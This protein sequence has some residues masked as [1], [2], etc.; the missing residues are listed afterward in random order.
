MVTRGHG[1]SRGQLR[2]AIDGGNIW[3]VAPSYQVASAIWIDLKRACAGAWVKKSE[4]KFRIELPG[5]G[6]VTVKSADNPESLRGDG[7]DGLVIDEA[8][9]ISKPEVWRQALRP[10]LSDKQGWAV[11]IGSPKGFNWLYDLWVAAEH[12]PGWARWQRPS[13][14]NPLMTASELA[15][16]KREAGSLA[17]AQEYEAQFTA[18]GLG[19]FLREWFMGDGKIVPA[20]PA[21][22]KRAIRYWDKAA[23]EAG[24]DFSAGVLAAEHDGFT[25]IADVVRGQWSA[26]VRNQVIGDT[27]KRDNERFPRMWTWFEQEGG[28][29]GK[30]SAELSREQMRKLGFLANTEKVTD[31]KNVRAMDF[32]AS[33]EAGNVRLIK[34]PW[35]AAFIDE[36]CVFTGSDNGSNDDQVDAASGAHRKLSKPTKSFYVGVA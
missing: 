9:S 12:L 15:D 24:G 29:G 32:S 7:L 4:V 11:F 30:E 23:T 20:L 6:S 28:S 36:L 14:D 5:G 27:A 25:Y 19:L 8:A 2:G 31:P 33:C 3:W 26:H 22:A 10:A 17:F 13:S 34:G 18:D 16:A 35:N 21:E 1:S